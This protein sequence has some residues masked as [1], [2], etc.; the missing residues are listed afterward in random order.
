M[1][2]LLNV[3]NSLELKHSKWFRSIGEGDISIVEQAYELRATDNK[4]EFVI[5][6]NKI[7][8]TKAYKVNNPTFS[9]IDL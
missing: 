6:N 9:N 8:G 5:E 7:I 2:S 4:R 3:D 1:E